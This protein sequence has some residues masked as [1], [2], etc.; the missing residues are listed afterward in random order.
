[1]H[2][3]KYKSVLMNNEYKDL[4]F[5]IKHKSGDKAAKESFLMQL[6]LSLYQ[7]KV[8]CYNFWMLYVIFIKKISIK[9][10]Q[11]EMRKESRCVTK[12][13]HNTK[14]GSNGGNEG[15]NSH[16]TYRKQNSKSKSFPVINTFK[17]KW[18]KLST[19]KIQIGRIN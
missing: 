6:K 19:Q 5:D 7:F 11:T 1:M 15:Q 16:E 8:D 18:T 10:T 3:N 9:Y 4:I 12:K 2:E 14:E 13:S 17:C